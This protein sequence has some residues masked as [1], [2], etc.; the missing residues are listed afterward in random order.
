MVESR[1][2]KWVQASSNRLSK[3]IPSTLNVPESVTAQFKRPKLRDQLPTSL[4]SNK[5]DEPEDGPDIYILLK[6]F[7]TCS[8]LKCLVNEL[9]IELDAVVFI[10]DFPLTNEVNHTV[11]PRDEL[12]NSH[13]LSQLKFENLDSPVGS[14]WSQIAWV[15][16]SGRNSKHHFEMFDVLAQR[17]YKILELK[18]LH[19][20][21]NSTNVV[22]IYRPASKDTRS[23]NL[24]YGSKEHGSIELYLSSL[25]TNVSYA[26]KKFESSKSSARPK[27]A[28]SVEEKSV[29]E[30][31]MYKSYTIELI[32]GPDLSHILILWANVH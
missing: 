4:S 20:K 17:I 24:D 6:D 10:N 28:I 25:L 31:S 12:S 7:T 1:P 9:K 22:N 2:K 8:L 29:E 5:S 30:S 27:R 23:Q 32:K 14:V 15:N 19:I 18:K 3:E 26:E 13:I 11:I 16:I 21:I